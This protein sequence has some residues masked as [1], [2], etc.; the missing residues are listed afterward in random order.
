MV[1]IANDNT[2]GYSQARR[3]F[4]P[5]IDCSSFV[6]YALIN[7]GGFSTSQLGTYPFTTRTM[8]DIL[9]SNGFTAHKFTGLDNLQE[10]DILWRSGHTEVY[11]GAGKTVGAHG[12]SPTN[13]HPN[14]SCSTSGDQDDEVSVSSAG[15]NWTY[16]FRYGS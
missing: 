1:N 7:A 13:S 11:A 5:D 4:N 15:T 8:S 9:T 16:Y 14:R 2:H 6:Y 3:T 10:G 12:C